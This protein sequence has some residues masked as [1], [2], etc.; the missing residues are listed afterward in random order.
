MLSVFP[1]VDTPTC[2]ASVRKFNSVASELADTV[3]LCIS[4]D[5]PF[6]HARFCGSADL[7]ICGSADLEN[8]HNLS[9]F[10]NR[11][12]LAEYGVA[13]EDGPLAGLAARAAIV[14]DAADKVVHSQL[15]P[16]ISEKPE[17]DAA[18]AALK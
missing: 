16:E 7:R 14:L 18:L 9:A 13:I 12:F 2:A 8:V 17:Y 11:E 15:V 1:S 3:V 10:R 5:L 4:A 6:A